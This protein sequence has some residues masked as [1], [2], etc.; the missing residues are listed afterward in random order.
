MTKFSLLIVE[1]CLGC[2]TP[3]V[4]SFIDY[5]QVF[6]SVDRRGLAK[7]LS[8]YGIPDKYTKVIG[9]M[10]ENYIAVVKVG[11]EFSSWFRIKSGVKQCCILSPFIRII[12][13]DF[14]LRSTG[15]A[16]EDHWIQWENTLQNLDYADDLSIFN[17]SVC[18]LNEFLEVFRVQGAR[19]GLKF[20]VKK[21]KSLW[22]GIRENEKVTLGNRKSNEVD[23]FTYLGNFISKVGGCNEYVESRIAQDVFSLLK[24]FGKIGR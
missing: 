19:I 13:M 4:L 22:L 5:E 14:V 17:Q 2:Q 1:K 20:S 12:L 3:L 16:M 7:V 9:A 10:Y 23:S 15:K 11:N 21:T 18:K 6:D 8:L 24:K